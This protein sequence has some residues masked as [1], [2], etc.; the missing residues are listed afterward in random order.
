M[1]TKDA[2]AVVG[3][4]K[5]LCRLLNCHRS[6]IYQWGSEVPE[7]RQYE[8]EVKTRRKLKSDYT[9]NRMN[10]APKRGKR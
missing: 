4:I 10:N 1:K 7:N 6:A 9:L 5:E 8:I 2:L 3:G